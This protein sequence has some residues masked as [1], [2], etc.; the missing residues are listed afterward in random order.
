MENIENIKILLV[1]S[2]SKITDDNGKDFVA[3]LKNF[4]DMFKNVEML[5]GSVALCIT[6]VGDDLD[7]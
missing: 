1:V 4:T 5:Q 7:L 3:S 2:E 6:K